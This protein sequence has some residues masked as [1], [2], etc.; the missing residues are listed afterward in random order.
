MI[1]RLVVGL[2]VIASTAQ[3]QVLWD[4]PNVASAADAQG[5]SYKI[6]ITAPGATSPSTLTLASV[7]C[8]VSGTTLPLTA[9]CQ[10]PAAQVVALG[11]TAP[12]ASSQLTAANTFGES[13]KS[14][15]PFLV[16]G[17]VD[18]TSVKV[19]VGTWARTLPVGGVGQ[20]LFSLLQ[21]K[22]N[23]TTVSVQFNG[24]EQGRVDGAR[25]NTIAGSY[26]TATVPAGTY[27]L[28]VQA[29]D[30][31]GCTDGGAARPMTVVVQ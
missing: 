31:A 14:S 15:P 27:Q 1:A 17:C 25:L 11:A 3:A 16:P 9:A 23:V 20:V 30:A 26:F 10:A 8:T 4:Q 6:Y 5:L 13:P 7:A 22:T 24:I 18:P 29:T 19:V 28:T 12:G 21:S 2:C